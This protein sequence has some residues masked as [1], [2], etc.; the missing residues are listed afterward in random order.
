[1]PPIKMKHVVDP[2]DAILNAVGTLNYM[3]LAANQVLVAVYKRPEET[4]GGIIMTSQT[5]DEDHYQSKVGLVLAIGPTA[6]TIDPHAADP[7]PWGFE[8]LNVDVH[9]WVVFRPSDGW[10][11]DLYDMS[12]EKV[13]CRMLQDVSIRAK[14]LEPDQVW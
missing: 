6:F 3:T 12:G 5:R 2:R 4:A 11:L 13:R 9:D 10:A 8:N 1:M 7:D 14:I